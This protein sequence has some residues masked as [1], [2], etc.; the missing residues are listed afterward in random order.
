MKKTLVIGASENTE[1][2]SNKAIRSLLNH[3]HEVEGIGAKPGKVNT[4]SFDRNKKSFDEIDTVTLY[5]GPKN[6]PEFYDYILDEIRPKRIIFN[7]GTE[8]TEFMKLAR[9]KG[10]IVEEAC[11]LVLLSIN[12]Y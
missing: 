11:T 2:Y 5:V 7:P 12:Q 3:G 1:R 6:Q 10:I 9:N 8:N 4:V